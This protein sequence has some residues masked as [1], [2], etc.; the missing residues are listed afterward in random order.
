MQLHLFKAVVSLFLI[1][2]VK[3]LNTLHIKG[4]LIAY[5]D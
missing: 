1:V 4:S 2:H 3:D 5:L